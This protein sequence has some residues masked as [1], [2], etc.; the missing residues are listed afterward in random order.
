MPPLANRDDET[1]SD[2]DMIEEFEVSFT[3]RLEALA[4]REIS[5]DDFEAALIVA[6]EARQALS[7]RTD[8]ENDELSSLEEMELTIN[9]ATYKVEDLADV[10]IAEDMQMDEES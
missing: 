10:E 4:N 5:V 7:H 2:D 1:E 3:P 8:V 6:L 9:G